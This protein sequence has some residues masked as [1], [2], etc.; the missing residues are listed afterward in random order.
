MKCTASK[1]KDTTD[2]DQEKQNPSA[3]DKGGSKTPSPSR[4]EELFKTYL[5]SDFHLCL[6]AF[7]RGSN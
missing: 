1:W 5:L 4:G 3:P 2:Q 6:S 7:A